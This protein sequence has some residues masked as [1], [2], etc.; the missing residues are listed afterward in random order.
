MWTQGSFVLSQITPL[1][2]RQT[3]GRMD[4]RTECSSLYRVC[5]S[6]R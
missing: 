1:T 2:D 3:N 4:G 5:I 6:A